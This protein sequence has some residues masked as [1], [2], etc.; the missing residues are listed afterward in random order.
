MATDEWSLL[1][2]SPPDLAKLLQA[3]DRSDAKVRRN[4]ET[5]RNICPEGFL[6]SQDVGCLDSKDVGC[7]DRV[8][9]D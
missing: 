1:A 5:R 2:T 6:D 3:I 9:F 8:S 4:T 7:L